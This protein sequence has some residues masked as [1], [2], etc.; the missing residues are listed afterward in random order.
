MMKK[1]K[2]MNKVEDVPL[3]N[4]VAKFAHQFNK[5]K[6]FSDKS[7]YTRKEKHEEQEASQSVLPRAN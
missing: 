5:A 2:N 7:K 6:V 1:R 3:Q 4:P